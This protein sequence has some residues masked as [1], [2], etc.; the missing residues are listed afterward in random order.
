MSLAMLVD[1]VMAVVPASTPIPKAVPPGEKVAAPLDNL[2]E[3][4]Q[5]AKP[6]EP[7]TPQVKLYVREYRVQGA[8]MLN[9]LEVQEAV[10]PFLGPGRTPDDVDQARMALEKAYRDKGFQTVTVEIPEQRANRG[11]VLLQVVENKVGRL[12]VKGSRY[13]SLDEIKRRAPSVAEGT[14]PNF[15]DITRDIVGLNQLPGRQ[16]SP[17]LKPG[18]APGTVDIDLTVKDTPPLHG[19]IELNNRYSADTVPLRINASLSYNNLWQLGHSLGMSYQV[20]PERP[21][22][23]KVFSGFYSVRFPAVPWLSLVLQGTKQDSNVSTLGGAAVNGKGE[24]IGGR[25]IVTLP[26]GPGFFHSLSLGFDYKHFDEAVRFG[27]SETLTPVYYYPFSTSYNATWLKERTGAGDT[28]AEAPVNYGWLTELNLAINHH[29]RGM[30]SSLAGFDS[31]RFKADGSYF[32]LRGDLTHTHDL[33]AG[34]QVVAKVQGQ[35]ASQPLLNSEQFAAGG[36]STVR[37]Y[38]ESTA[39][40]D[41]GIFGTLEL[42]SPSILGS[43]KDKDKDKTN[44]WRFYLF[45]EGGALSLNDA[46]PDQEP[47]IDLASMGIGTFIDLFEHFHGSLDVG[48]PLIGQGQIKP[49]DTL[50]TFRVWADF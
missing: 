5:P 12:R 16:V 43:H 38:L 8:R 50:L 15:N 37:G 18:V 3:P 40:G 30:G 24:I 45:C 1:S 41:N 39:L 49:H 11:I 28:A 47:R 2:R 7:V 29:F 17:S 31:K 48:V 36:L 25:A 10:Y 34:L 22:D 4:V 9:P 23:A 19:S 26:P 46:L 42:H 20:A 21:D 6:E 32:Y 13:Y 27:F 14:V 33:P 35:A 44:E